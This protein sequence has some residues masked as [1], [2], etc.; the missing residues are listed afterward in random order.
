MNNNNFSIIWDWNGTLVDDAPVFINIM[1]FFLS[2]RNLPLI[3]LE[4]YRRSFVFP[5]KNYY[6][7]LGF[8]FSKESFLFPKSAQSFLSYS[9]SLFALEIFLSIHVT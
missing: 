8:D 4:D 9:Q 3:T 2:Q 7:N 5:V 1:N 6:K